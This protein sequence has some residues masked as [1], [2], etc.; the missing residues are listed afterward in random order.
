MFRLAALDVDHKLVVGIDLPQRDQQGWGRASRREDAERPWLNPELVAQ[1]ASVERTEGDH[2]RHSP[3]AALRDDKDS[4]EVGR[5]P[6]RNSNEPML[7][8]TPLQGSLPV[9]IFCGY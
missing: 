5:G 8:D 2:H 6:G 7:N 4:E 3:W 9:E 1:I